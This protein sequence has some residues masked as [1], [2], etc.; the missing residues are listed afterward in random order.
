[1]KILKLRPECEECR[2]LS[3]YTPETSTCA[4]RQNPTCYRKKK[5]CDY[6]CRTFFTYNIYHTCYGLFP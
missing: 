2:H 4:K 6:Y 5:L 3:G 1:M